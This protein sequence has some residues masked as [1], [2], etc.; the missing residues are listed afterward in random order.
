MNLYHRCKAHV[1]RHFDLFRRKP[2]CRVQYTMDLHYIAEVCVS[3]FS[4]KLYWRKH[5]AAITAGNV[6]VFVG[7]VTASDNSAVTATGWSWAASDSSITVA[8]DPSD[9]SGA[10][11]DVTVPVSDTATTFVLKASATAVSAT[12][13]TPTPVSNTVTVTINPSSVPV[14]FTLNISQTS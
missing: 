2:L 13:S 12:E 8:T 1:Q 11:V 10:T 9:A 6:G 5:M 3:P 7:T 14:T 4:L